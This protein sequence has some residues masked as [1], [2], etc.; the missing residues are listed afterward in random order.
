[1][2]SFCIQLRCD[3]RK[4]NP[5]QISNSQYVKMELVNIVY[6]KIGSVYF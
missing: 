1:M 6:N 2:Q 4:D 5:V 3:Y